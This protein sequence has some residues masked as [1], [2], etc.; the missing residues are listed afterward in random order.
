MSYAE[1]LARGL[2]MVTLFALLERR[3]YRKDQ[4]KDLTRA[5][6]HEVLGHEVDKDGNLVEKQAGPPPDPRESGPAFH[7]RRTLRRFKYPEWL[8]DQMIGK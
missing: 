6:I 5:W 7:R 4:I 1:S 3:G 2:S 8:I